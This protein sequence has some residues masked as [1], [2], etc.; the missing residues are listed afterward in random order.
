MKIQIDTEH[1]SAYFNNVYDAV[2]YA[3]K[4]C[5][6]DDEPTGVFICPDHEENS[7]MTTR[8]WFAVKLSDFV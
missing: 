8:T 6:A 7:D 4:S 1:G 2:F 3:K 5:E